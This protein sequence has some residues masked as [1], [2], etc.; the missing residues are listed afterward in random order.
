MDVKYLGDNCLWTTSVFFIRTRENTEVFITFDDNIYGIHR[1]RV[2][3]LYIL[4]N[5]K[6]TAKDVIKTL[7]N[8]MKRL[9][10]ALHSYAQ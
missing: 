7:K 8:V 3:I 2:N 10:F 6:G 1:K 9:L 5:V 4:S